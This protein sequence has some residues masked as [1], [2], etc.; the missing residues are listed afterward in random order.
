MTW[1]THTTFGVITGQILGLNPILAGIGATAPDWFE[2][3][4]GIKEHRGKTHYVIVWYPA[5]ILISMIY[6]VK[7]IE[8]NNYIMSFI[9]GGATHILL[10]S[11]TITGVPLGIKKIRIR[12]GGLI[13]TGSASEYIFLGAFAIALMPFVMGGVSLGI[14]NVRGLY[15]KGIIDKK[16]YNEMKFK[17]IN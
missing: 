11:L 12:I 9:Y 13:K 10:D 17:I 2:D 7:P 1:I 15:K 4:L 8:I 16:E 6:L 14:N 3:F 5:L